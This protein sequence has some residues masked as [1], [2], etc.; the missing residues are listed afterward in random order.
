MLMLTDG[1]F[2]SVRITDG[3]A[4]QIGG[5]HNR[6]TGRNGKGSGDGGCR[7]R[8]PRDTSGG[9]QVRV[10]QRDQAR[11]ERDDQEPDRRST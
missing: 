5:L 1:A 2:C 9:R 4:A 7:Y 11:V 6:L 3:F 10:I 8:V